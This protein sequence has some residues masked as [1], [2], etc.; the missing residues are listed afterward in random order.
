MDVCR[1]MNCGS[2][3]A[4]KRAET[5]GPSGSEHVNPPTEQQPLLTGRMETV[6]SLESGPAPDSEVVDIASER[7]VPA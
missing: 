1:F 7:E 3:V 5:P 6:P 4:R 2:G